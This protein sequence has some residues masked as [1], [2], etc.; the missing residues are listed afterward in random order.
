MSRPLAGGSPLDTIYAVASGTA[1]SA[2]TVVRVSGDRTSAILQ[3]LTGRLPQPRKAS[4]RSVRSGGRVLDRGLVLW[5]P[6]PGSYTG[7]D[8]AEL[9]LHGGAA[10][11]AA[12]CAA[13]TACGAR[14]AD[15]GEFTRRAVLGGKM[16]VFEAEAIGELA[17]AET[18]AQR[19]LAM[20][21]LLGSASREIHAWSDRLL[22]LLATEEALIDFPDETGADRLVLRQL[23]DI[24]ELAAEIA[25][26]LDQAVFG[27]RRRSGIVIAISGPPNVGKSTLFNALVG[28]EA[29]IVSEQPGTTRDVLEA[30]LDLGGIA[31]TLI[32]TAGVRDTADPVEAE[33]VRRARARA[34]AADIVLDL[35]C[36]EAR[37][38]YDP[39]DRVITVA[40]KCDIVPAGANALAVSATTFAGMD[41]LRATLTERARSLISADRDPI[42]SN[43][44]QVAALGETHASLTAAAQLHL[45]SELRAEELRMAANSLGRLAGRVD[46]EAVLDVVFSSF[47]IGK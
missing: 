6:G 34:L 2:I 43:A 40:S 45:L 25:Q 4:V 47:C 10:I 41:I 37:L 44:R 20:S 1:Q 28:R 30:A 38:A 24:R 21:A 3:E 8:T 36:G 29:A 19:S 26:H 15:A 7:E 33:G 12:V 5:M 16:D 42:L 27:E 13:L 35:Q 11:R 32:D 9:H 14:P 17:R 18:E 22:R 31:V 39:D 23:T 46:T